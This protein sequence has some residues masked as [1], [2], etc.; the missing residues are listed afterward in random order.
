MMLL[1]DDPIIAR[2]E[3]TGYPWDD[4]E[5]PEE[6]DDYWNDEPFAVYDPTW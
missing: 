3:R 5:V 1:S 4:E 2:M 6:H